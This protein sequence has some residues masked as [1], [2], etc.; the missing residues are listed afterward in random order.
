MHCERQHLVLS[1][2]TVS[3]LVGREGGEGGEGPGR[4]MGH[5]QP[6]LPLRALLLVARGWRTA[7]HGTCGAHVVCG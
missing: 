5:A 1:A 4:C 3:A 2:G 7:G 6:T